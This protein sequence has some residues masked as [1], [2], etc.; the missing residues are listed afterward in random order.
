MG[1]ILPVNH[2]QYADYQVREIKK[3][4]KTM[5]IERPFKIIAAAQ[6][7]KWNKN[8]PEYSL[9]NRMLTTE[10]KINKGIYIDKKI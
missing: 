4:R 8:T 9:Y 7:E 5:F 3:A 1:Y 10:Q 2:I 6:Y